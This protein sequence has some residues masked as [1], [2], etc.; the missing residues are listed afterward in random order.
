MSIVTRLALPAILMAAATAALAAG[1]PPA[2][3]S[4]TVQASTTVAP[5]TVRPQPEDKVIC[6][7]EVATGSR[8]GGV[9]R[10]M[11]KSDWEVEAQA[12]RRERT[13]AAPAGIAGVH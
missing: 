8:L 6:K 12:A 7:T 4:A 1:E 11:K 3:P 2:N 9:R 13:F 10:C 5:A